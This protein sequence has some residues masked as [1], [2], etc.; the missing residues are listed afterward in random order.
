M[1]E[2][3]EGKPIQ[4]GKAA[5]KRII[6]RDEFSS[7]EQA[8]GL[9]RAAREQAQSI[10]EDAH[11]EA[12]SIREAARREGDELLAEARLQAQ[13]LAREEHVR[14][15][16]TFVDGTISHIQ[17]LEHRL[18]GIVTDALERLL[19]ERG[20]EVQIKALVRRM[21]RGI[22]QD[23]RIRL[24]VSEATYPQAEKALED[25]MRRWQNLSL[26]V[27]DGT[28]DDRLVLECNAGIIEACLNEQVENLRRALDLQ[29]GPGAVPAPPSV[30]DGR[31]PP[32]P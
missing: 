18:A 29:L 31:D 17:A 11:E 14:R 25:T 2:A 23:E 3:A 4:L 21:L 1:S 10:I 16:V 24:N 28:P 12:R 6:G 19:D 32:T 30:D 7:L 5:V 13:A 26:C 27:A 9:H 22:E 20:Q 15:L 8:Q